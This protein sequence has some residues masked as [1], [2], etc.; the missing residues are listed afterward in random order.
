MDERAIP[1]R[2]IRT[3]LFLIACLLCLMAGKFSNDPWAEEGRSSEG[4]VTNIHQGPCSRMIH[5]TQV[6]LEIQPRPVKAM[7]DLTFTVTLSGM[8]PAA[9][10][11]VDL[12]MP[13]MT[14]GPNRVHLRHTGPGRYEGQ[15]IIVRC[16][17]GSRTWEA[18]VTVPGAGEAAFVFDV[19]D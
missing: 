13:G 16:P 6:T 7:E 14:M 9:D 5:G 1:C 12:G 10:P 4:R 17:T 15:G 18:R 19:M 8:E 11:Y 2:M 3:G